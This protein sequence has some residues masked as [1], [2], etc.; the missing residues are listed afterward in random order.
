M[1]DD[2]L[3]I[4]GVILTPNKEQHVFKGVIKSK[5]RM[6]E[7]GL[8]DSQFGFGIFSYNLTNGAKYLS[9]EHFLR[10]ANR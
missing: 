5:T 9:L 1:N 2:I 4:D 7:E 8:D 3:D 6:L 10:S